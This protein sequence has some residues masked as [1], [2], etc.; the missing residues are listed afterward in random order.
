MAVFF[1]GNDLLKARPKSLDVGREAPF[2][3]R[4]WPEAFRKVPLWRDVLGEPMEVTGQI[5]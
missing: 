5:I 4:V 3:C 1:S 2:Y